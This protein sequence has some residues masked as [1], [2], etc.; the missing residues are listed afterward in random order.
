MRSSPP[1][2]DGLAVSV[3]N[4]AYADKKA[5]LQALAGMG[6]REIVSHCTG[7]GGSTAALLELDDT[8]GAVEFADCSG[9]IPSNHPY[10]GDELLVAAPWRVDGNRPG[11][12]KP[13]PL[14]GE[15]DDFVLRR[16][17][18]LGDAE[19]D[20]LNAT[21]VVGVP[22]AKRDNGRDSG[23][24]IDPAGYRRTIPTPATSCWFLVCRDETL[25]YQ[26]V[27][28]GAIDRV[29]LDGET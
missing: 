5:L 29:S 12:R 3:P 10:T 17:L 22:A 1:R 14:L 16:I 9:W 11:L 15:S 21:G 7:L 25:T 27:E 13:A 4:G 23:K 8:D 28:K 20:A 26:P 19:I 24:A 6:Y 18:S 2:M